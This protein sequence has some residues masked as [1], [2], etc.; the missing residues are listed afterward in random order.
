MKNA[1]LLLLSIL[2][3]GA[4]FSQT[5]YNGIAYFQLGSSP[6]S[7]VYNVG[8]RVVYISSSH[9]MFWYNENM[10][11]SIN[12]FEIDPVGEIETDIPQSSKSKVYI[13]NSVKIDGLEIND[14]WLYFLND[15]LINFNCQSS[16]E[17]NEA[18]TIKYGNSRDTI[19]RKPVK[20][21][22]KYTGAK[23]EEKELF[24]IKKWIKGKFKA[25]STFH[26]YYDSNCKNHVTNEMNYRNEK[27]IAKAKTTA[28]KD[29]LKGK[30]IKQ[31]LLEKKK[32]LK[33]F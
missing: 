28:L 33:N 2:I 31:E 12:I 24:S 20:C 30:Q 9:N 1:L 11:D 26:S 10:K 8:G 17:L 7:I 5:Q 32:T 6:D 18:M 16:E 19:I 3:Q 22:Y 15:S 13:I 29:D 4:A 25:T 21:S 27:S 23:F 14:I